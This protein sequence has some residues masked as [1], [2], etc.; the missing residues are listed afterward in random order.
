MKPTD[1]AIRQRALD[2]QRS[3]IVRAPAG[4]G[5]THLLIQRYLHLLTCVTE[6]EHI[7]A[8]TFTRKA[9]AEMK[10]RIL[11]RLEEND[12][13]VAKIRK[14]DKD[15]NWQ[16][17]DMPQR[18]QIMTIDGFCH[19]ITKEFSQECDIPLNARLADQPMFLYEEAIHQL[20]LKTRHPQ[21]LN[22][23]LMHQR[24]NI[25]RVHRLF[26]ELLSK[27]DQWLSR[28]LGDPTELLETLTAHFATV[29]EEWLSPIVNASKEIQAQLIDILT[30]MHGHLLNQNAEHPFCEINPSNLFES[31]IDLDS[32]YR[33]AGLLLTKSGHW[34]TR[35]TKREGVPPQ[36]TSL[37]ED[38][39]TLLTQWPDTFRK[40]LAQLP[41][42]PT[43][44]LPEHEKSLLIHLNQ[45]LPEL[46]GQLKVSFHRHRMV[47]FIEITQAAHQLMSHPSQAA[48]EIH[49]RIRHIMI[50]EFQ[51]TAPLQ[52]KLVRSM[53]ADWQGSDRTL[54]L[55]G[56]PMQSIYRFRQ[57]DVRLFLQL[58]EVGDDHLNL[59]PL[60]L[61]DNFRSD[62]HL[63][64]GSNLLF[65]HLFPE[66][67]N[68]NHSAISHQLAHPVREAKHQMK[69]YPIDKKNHAEKTA[70]ICRSIKN[71]SIAILTRTRSQ[72]NQV[73]TALKS[74]GTSFNGVDLIPLIMQPVGAD[75]LNLLT[76]LCEPHHRAAWLSLLRSPLIGLLPE[77]LLILSRSSSTLWKSIQ[78]NHADLSSHSQH[79]LS[80]VVPLL[81]HAI[82]QRNQ[83]THDWLWQ[84]WNQLEGPKAYSSSD[85]PAIAS[86][87]SALKEYD[88]HALFPLHSFREHLETLYFS[89]LNPQSHIHLM[90]IHKSK[91]LEFDHVILP[92][93][94][95]NRRPPTDALFVWD[96]YYDSDNHP[97][98]LV[99][100]GLTEHPQARAIR[101]LGQ[102][103]E[104][105]EN[106]RLLYVAVTRAKQTCRFIMPEKCPENSWGGMIQHTIESVPQTEQHFIT[107]ESNE[108]FLESSIEESPSCVTSYYPQLKRPTLVIEPYKAEPLWNPSVDRLLGECIH[109]AY[110]QLSSIP[111]STQ[112]SHLFSQHEH[113]ERRYKGLGMQQKLD[114]WR[115]AIKNDSLFSWI[116]D[117]HTEAKTEHSLIDCREKEFKEYR[118]DRSFIY[119]GK[120]WIIDLKTSH[121][122]SQPMETFL[123]KEW[124]QYR[125]QLSTY[126]NLFKVIEPNR[127][128]EVALY[129]PLLSV[130]VYGKTDSNSYC[131]LNPNEERSNV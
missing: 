47:D 79:Q 49:E 12:A 116:Y 31:P 9:A 44:E 22:E 98:P 55:V 107:R 90:T 2:T 122:R 10:H 94:H 129:F 96:E 106:K 8:I 117:Q 80:C 35:F 104:N 40:T 53:T 32:W 46:Y 60:T 128:I 23:L 1:D 86:F 97:L 71:G 83:T 72:L 124:Q 3:F 20:M 64:H 61:Q 28:M 125:T 84:L 110:A 41:L 6:P 118:I 51:D 50:D 7:L 131:V 69:I 87:F 67:M 42:I 115:K 30:R 17:K 99:A 111:K 91:G 18:L 13:L 29:R 38:L 102:Q 85:Q 123:N 48:A 36:D 26:S 70:R 82:S 74:S 92:F 78:S 56:D 63:I 126:A 19:Q 119:N 24:G 108:T 5:K 77:D 68:L 43:A 89:E 14:R 37:K 112:R 59:E 113:A 114:D 11:K 33:V 73:A 130:A 95:E 88:R 4:S 39:T 16:L 109:K 52:F 66:Q 93:L 101:W 54:F 15:L 100:L 25:A 75:L 120:R 62:A 34:R 27:R 103:K 105:Y 65:Q 45:L 76:A 57:A 121:C 58:F 127:P 81:K 21:S